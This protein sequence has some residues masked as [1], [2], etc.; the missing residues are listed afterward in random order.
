MCLDF[1]EISDLA[2][3]RI[4]FANY[5]VSDCMGT[6]GIVLQKPGWKMEDKSWQIEC[7]RVVSGRSSQVY[8]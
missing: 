6:S 4:S 8:T 1:W 2:S 5:T 7:V 3:Q